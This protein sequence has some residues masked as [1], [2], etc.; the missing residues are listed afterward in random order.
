MV[1]GGTFF[2]VLPKENVAPCMDCGIWAPARGSKFAVQ[3]ARSVMLVTQLNPVVSCNGS[4]LIFAWEQNPVV[5]DKFL[6][7]FC[8]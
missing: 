1:I 3:L 5:L 7:F 6:G 4:P 8:G 2:G